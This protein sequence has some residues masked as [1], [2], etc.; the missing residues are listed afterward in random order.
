MQPQQL[1]VELGGG[2]LAVVEP[3]VQHLGGVTVQRDVTR[4]QP[5]DGDSFVLLKEAKL[6]V[7]REQVAQLLVIELDKQTLQ[8]V[9]G[10]HLLKDLLVHSGDDAGATG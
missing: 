8:S 1:V 2:G 5:L 3:F 4:F 6:R 9:V 7:G 10:A